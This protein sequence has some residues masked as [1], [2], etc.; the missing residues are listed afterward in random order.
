MEQ[1]KGIRKREK[2]V[3]LI[4]ERTKTIYKKIVVLVKRGT[5]QI[6]NKGKR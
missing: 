5:K 1:K 4:K 3:V 6:I 2:M